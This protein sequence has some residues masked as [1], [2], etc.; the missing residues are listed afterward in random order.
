MWVLNVAETRILPIDYMQSLRAM[1][2]LCIV[3]GQPHATRRNRGG[4]TLKDA[5]R[6]PSGSARVSNLHFGPDNPTS[7]LDLSKCLI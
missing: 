6:Q 3:I 7:S 2:M 4:P 1:P 5:W